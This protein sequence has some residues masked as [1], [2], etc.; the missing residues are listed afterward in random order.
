MIV[1]MIMTITNTTMFINTNTKFFKK[2]IYI[3]SGLGRSVYGRSHCPYEANRIFNLNLHIHAIHPPTSSIIVSPKTKL[4]HWPLSTFL[5]TSFKLW[6]YPVEKLS[7][8]ITNWLCLSKNSRR[9]NL[10]QYL[11][12]ACCWRC[13][14][15]F[16]CS[17]RLLAYRS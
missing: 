15:I 14:W 3:F 5:F 4:F 16:G 1:T 8:P 10:W 11:D 2:F 17:S 6:K 7:T 12:T 13:W 9:K